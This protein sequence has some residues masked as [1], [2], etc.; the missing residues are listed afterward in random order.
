MASYVTLQKRRILVTGATGNQGG[1]VIEAL[2]SSAEVDSLEILALTRNP[3]SPKAQQLTAKSKSIILLRGDLSDCA[4]IFKAASDPILAVFSVQTDVYG[5]PEKVS[6]GEV[7]G[8]ALIDAAVGHGVSHFVQASGDRGGPENSD[9]DPTSVPQFITKF[10][11]ENHL[12]HQKAMTWTILR[13]SSFMENCASDLHGKGFAAMWSCMEEK[14]LQLV[15][16]KDIGIFAARAI[17]EST[18]PTFKNRAISLAGDEL[19]YA[20]AA[21]IF[22]DTKGK[23]MPK[24]PALVGTLVQWQTPE[25]KSM[26]GWFKNVGFRADIEE[27]RKINPKMLK[28]QSWLKETDNYR[29]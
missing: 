5:S 26:F 2:T 1:A 16:T 7:Q 17:L 6:Q 11:V 13:P 25:L 14:P 9:V 24:A 3:S 28:F 15:S 12:K 19:T 8:C 21:K 23:T 20:Q 27:C 10:V 4:A 22:K 18:S 29:R